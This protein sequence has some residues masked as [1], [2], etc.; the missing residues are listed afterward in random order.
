MGF[1]LPQGNFGG[2]DFFLSKASGLAI[3][4][5]PLVHVFLLNL[6]RNVANLLC[7]PAPV[8][9][10][11]SV[12]ILRAL[13]HWLGVLVDEMFAARRPGVHIAGAATFAA[14]VVWCV[15]LG[16]PYLNCSAIH[17]TNKKSVAWTT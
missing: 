10:E 16:S 2:Y 7:W 3:C 6:K 14:F 13:N 8:N 17:P 12:L 15:H 11:R 5:F 9:Q 1:R 4:S